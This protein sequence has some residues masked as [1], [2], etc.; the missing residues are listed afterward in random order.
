MDKDGCEMC[1]CGLGEFDSIGFLCNII[2]SILF[3]LI[4]NNCL[5]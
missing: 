1:L 5:Y 4:Y 2:F 3:Y